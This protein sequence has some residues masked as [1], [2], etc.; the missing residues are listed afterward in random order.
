MT[1]TMQGKTVRCSC[2]GQIS[3]SGT[4]HPLSDFGCGYKGK[5]FI[6]NTEYAK[7]IIGYTGICMKC[8]TEGRFM[9]EEK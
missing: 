3:P 1:C 8:R 5:D 2:G 4:L 6:V 9:L 7:H